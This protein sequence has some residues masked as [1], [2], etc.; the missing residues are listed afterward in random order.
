[1]RAVFNDC[2]EARGFWTGLDKLH[3]ITF[4]ELKAARGAIESFL[5]ELKGRR[6]PMHED[7]QFV[8]GVLIHLT[9]RSPS[10]MSKL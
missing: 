1:M 5:S 10:M 6:L 4:K 7:N 8:V 2:I 9:S 3:H